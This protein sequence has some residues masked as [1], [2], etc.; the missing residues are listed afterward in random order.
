MLARRGCRGILYDALDCCMV[1]IKGIIK[2]APT[3][4]PHA[5]QVLQLSQHDYPIVYH[6]E[7]NM[8]DQVA[9]GHETQE[10]IQTFIA[11]YPFPL[12]QF[13]LDAIA[14]LA[15][16]QSVLVAAPTGTGKTL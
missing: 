7:E 8:D 2:D 15:E 6:K 11:R 12:D 14:Q 9:D 1:A 5:P 13:Q 3:A 16:G 4:C 10:N